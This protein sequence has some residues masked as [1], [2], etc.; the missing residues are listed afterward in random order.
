MKAK[1]ITLEKL[2]KY[3]SIFEAIEWAKDCIDYD[4]EIILSKPRKP[5]IKSS[6]TSDEAKLY[7]ESL[8]QYEKDLI[9]YKEQNDKIKVIKNES[10]NIIVEYIKELSGLNAIPKEYRDKVYSKAHANGHSG[11]YHEVYNDLCS[12]VEIFD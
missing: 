10:D 5:I 2:L 4:G 11:G 3:G 7:Y 8:V 6:P 1:P 9:L 12:L